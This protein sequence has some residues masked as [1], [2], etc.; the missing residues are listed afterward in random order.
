MN[1]YLI[2]LTVIIAI[3]IIVSVWLFISWRQRDKTESNHQ[4]DTT[5]NNL[6][7]ELISKQM[8]GLLSIQKSLETANRTLN[9][10]L[11]EGTTTIDRRMAVI[12]EIENKLGQLSKQT[13]NI[14]DIGSN[15]QS[16]SELLKPPKLRGNLGEIFLDNLLSQILPQGLYIKQYKFNDGSR[17]DAIIKL[18]NRLLPIDSK[19]PLESYQ[20][21]MADNSNDKQ[22]AQKKFSQT[23]RKH[24]D[25]INSK[26][27]KP[28]EKTTD[29]AIMYLPAEAIYYQYITTD[30]L[31]DFE[32]ALSKKVIPSSPGH[33]Y[34]FLASVSILYTETGLNTNPHRLA[35]TIKSL[36]ES[37][38]KLNN[39]NEKMNGSLR[40][41]VMNLDKSKE[42]TNRMEWQLKKLM[43]TEENTEKSE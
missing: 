28:Q 11:A 12:G 17:V 29:F 3:N 6:K 30:K 5:L 18:N 35:N 43:E 20:R 33:L 40:S 15:I 34:G 39:F 23:I 2:V 14:E 19:F 27:I 26:Y 21:L 32:Y 24:I 37:L 8:E 7:T 25:D 36:T 1:I 16:L 31:E 10:R 42:E 38:K 9:E 4:I 41:A 22:K 13:K